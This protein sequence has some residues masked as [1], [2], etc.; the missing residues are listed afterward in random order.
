M[1]PNSIILR[2]NFD[3]FVHHSSHFVSSSVD[4]ILSELSGSECD[5]KRRPSSPWLRPVRDDVTARPSSFCIGYGELGRSAV[6][7]L[8]VTAT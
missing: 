5:V 2:Y 8:A 7:S 3:N 6:H 4:L 1:A